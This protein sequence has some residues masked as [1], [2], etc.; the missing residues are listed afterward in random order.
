MSFADRVNAIRGGYE[1]KSGFRINARG[2]CEL[3]AAGHWGDDCSN[4]CPGAPN[5]TCNGHGTC[6]DGRLGHGRCSCNIGYVPT[7]TSSNTSCSISCDGG[8][9]NPCSGHGKCEQN[10]RCTCFETISLGFFTGSTCS[11][12]DPNYESPLCN[13]ACPTFNGTVCNGKGLCYNGKCQK[14][15]ILSTDMALWCGSKCELSSDDIPPNCLTC[16]RG[17]F[18]S[19]CTGLC[20]GARPDGTQPCSGHGV[21]DQGM[22]G[23]GTCTCRLGFSGEDCS[24]K[25]PGLQ[26]CSNHGTCFKGICTCSKGYATADCSVKCPAPTSNPNLI[27]SGRGNCSRVTGLHARLGWSGMRNH[28]RWW[29]RK[30][31]Q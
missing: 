29:G 21:C 3:C 12:C 31:L 14:C 4:L 26:P 8:T 11:A 1:C 10:G 7:N 25:C 22:A 5:S 20:R 6:D 19:R 23:T 30:A 15:G 9:S 2:A 27:C 17:F 13:V 24:E 16:P 18:G 28:V